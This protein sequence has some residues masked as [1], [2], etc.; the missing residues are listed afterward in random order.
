M[1]YNQG[2][3]AISRALGIY[4]QKRGW[5][6]TDEPMPLSTVDEYIRRAE[7]MV[8]EERALTR[9]EATAQQVRRLMRKLL[10]ADAEDRHRDGIAIEG[11]LS[12]IQGTE[13]PKTFEV[14]APGGG[15]IAIKTVP[16]AMAAFQRM[17]EKRTA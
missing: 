5:Q 6:P 10:K 4:L 13:A 9:Q 12:K 17:V 1:L 7:E 2:R 15:P 11:Q 16:E 14:S 8:R 3:R